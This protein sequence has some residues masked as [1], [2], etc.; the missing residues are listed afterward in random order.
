MIIILKVTMETIYGNL[1]Y[2]S[3]TWTFNNSLEKS[4]NG[5]YTKLL[6]M[7]LNVS[8]KDKWSNKKLYNEMPIITNIIATRRLS[9]T[10][11]CIRH[12]EESYHNLIFCLTSIMS[13]G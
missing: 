8:W 2:G 5:C 11:Y 6:R 9:N 1:L 10:G 12:N 3:E 7:V 13:E 4:S